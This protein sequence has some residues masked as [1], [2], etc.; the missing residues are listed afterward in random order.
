MFSRPSRIKIVLEGHQNIRDGLWDIPVHKSNIIPNNFQMPHLHPSI[1]VAQRKKETEKCAITTHNKVISALPINKIQFKNLESLIANQLRLDQ[2]L[3]PI[4]PHLRN[5]DSLCY[6]NLVSN[7]N[8]Q[9][10]QKR[11]YIQKIRVRLS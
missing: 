4:A 9:S 8:N 6:D 5:L 11:K 1:Y 2:L 10:I 7:Y 3:S